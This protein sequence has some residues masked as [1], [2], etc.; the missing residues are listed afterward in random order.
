MMQL[1]SFIAGR[2]V[3]GEAAQVLRSAINGQPV[4]RTH[5]EAIDFGEA[6]AHAREI[7]RAH[8]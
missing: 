4:A 7:G 8:V 2:W 6:L 3:G 1:Q 5:A